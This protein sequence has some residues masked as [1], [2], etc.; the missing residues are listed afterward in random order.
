MRTIEAIAASAGL[1]G[2]AVVY[3]A[4]DHSLN[5]RQAD[6]VAEETRALEVGLARAFLWIAGAFERCHAMV[7]VADPSAATSAEVHRGR[8]LQASACSGGMLVPGYD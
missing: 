7:E 1:L 2:C 5:G 8:I 4:T 3:A 6:A